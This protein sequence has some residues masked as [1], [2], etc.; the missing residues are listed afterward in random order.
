M[1][2]DWDTE[3]SETQLQETGFS[4]SGECEPAGTHEAKPPAVT[5]AA[6]GKW[7]HV[8][9]THSFPL[10]GIWLHPTCKVAGSGVRY[11]R[12]IPAGSRSI[13]G[14]QQKTENKVITAQESALLTETPERAGRAPAALL[15]DCRAVPRPMAAPTPI[16][17][18]GSRKS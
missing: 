12:G 11:R 15:Q 4:S 2:H 6:T 13:R 16:C 1:A 8:T 17:N 9:D 3:P 7:P 5:R 14:K 10:S 18:S